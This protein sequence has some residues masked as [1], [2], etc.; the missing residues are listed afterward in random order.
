M[1]F[2]FTPQ[3]I[4][5]EIEFEG[6]KKY[7]QIESNCSDEKLI[8]RIRCMFPSL[9][10]KTSA[11]PVTISSSASVTL[12]YS[13]FNYKIIGLL[14]KSD[15]KIVSPIK[16]SSLKQSGFYTVLLNTTSVF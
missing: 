8:Q 14:D 3:N 15:G 12:P 7:L 2:F 5:V 16:F 1:S 13:A 6:T 11:F 10:Y 9:L 4:T